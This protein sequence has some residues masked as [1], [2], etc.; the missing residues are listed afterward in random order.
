MVTI[1]DNQPLNRVRVRSIMSSLRFAIVVLLASSH[2]FAQTSSSLLQGTVSDSSGALVPNARV[3]AT[4]ANT[5]T[6]YST[7]TNESGN[8]VISDVRPGEYSISAEAAA[9]KRTVRTGVVIE[10]N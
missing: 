10:V 3:V 1:A 9:F 6:N 7:V 2:A 5:Q 8:Y 4:L